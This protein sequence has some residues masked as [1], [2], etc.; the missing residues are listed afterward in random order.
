MKKK[1]KIIFFSAESREP[2]QLMLIE[3]SYNKT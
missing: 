3:P 2:K 1:Q